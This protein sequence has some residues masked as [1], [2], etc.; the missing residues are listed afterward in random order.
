MRA[1]ALSRLKIHAGSLHR[2]DSVR[3]GGKK[4]T[5]EE[6]IEEPGEPLRRRRLPDAEVGAAGVVAANGGDPAGVR[7]DVP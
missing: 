5:K 2:S 4:Q 7:A 6:E 1:S 3:R